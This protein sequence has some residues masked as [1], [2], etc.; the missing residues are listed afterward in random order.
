MIN[1]GVSYNRPFRECI[2][3]DLPFGDI[4]GNRSL[5]CRIAFMC[6]LCACITTAI[7]RL[8]KSNQWRRWCFAA[9]AWINAHQI[10]RKLIVTS[11]IREIILNIASH[12]YYALS[13]NNLAASNS[14][15][16]PTLANHLR[17]KLLYI[18]ISNDVFYAESGLAIEGVNAWASSKCGGGTVMPLQAPPSAEKWK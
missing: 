12:N 3:I 9:S 15:D 10:S 11:I 7:Y 1:N 2:V 18:K 17:S 4:C 16:I 13:R 5:S 14:N 8:E 6:G